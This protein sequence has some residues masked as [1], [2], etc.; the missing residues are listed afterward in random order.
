[1]AKVIWAKEA[2]EDLEEI[3]LYLLGFSE[4]SATVWAS[5]ITQAAFLLESFPRMG[6][7]VPNINIERLRECVV[8]QYR[9]I[10]EV[11]EDDSLIEIMAIRHSSKPLSNT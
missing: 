3:Y 9:L 4:K 7:V 5:E 8:K 11:S 6:R 10:Y 1:M 2:R